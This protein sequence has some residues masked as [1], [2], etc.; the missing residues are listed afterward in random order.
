MRV[1][2]DCC[3]GRESLTGSS[4]STWHPGEVAACGQD[5]KVSAKCLGLVPGQG[6][7]FGHL[8]VLTF[9]PSEILEWLS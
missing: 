4:S 5:W 2:V 9:L 6:Q 1:G 7:V 8:G 3:V